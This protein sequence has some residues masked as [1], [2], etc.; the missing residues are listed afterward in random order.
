MYSK[1]ESQRIKKEFWTNFGIFSQKKRVYQ[2]LDKRWISHNTGINCLSLKFDFE[3][4][5]ALVGI[6]I[7][8]TNRKEEE[9]YYNRILQLKTVLHEFFDE[10]PIWDSDFDLGNGKFA[11]K[12]YHL[13]ENV[14]IHDK[15]CWPN[16]YQ[17]FYEF[18]LKYEQFF[19]EYKDFIKDH[20]E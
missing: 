20:S 19:I 2:G 11:V 10:E 7:Y 4:K 18:M 16:V 5:Q 14:N 13:L 15:S 17:F 9:K 6:E 12:I 3:R 8:T 1:E